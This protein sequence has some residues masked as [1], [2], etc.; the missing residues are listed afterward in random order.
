[1]PANPPF[2]IASIQIDVAV[3]NPAAYGNNYSVDKKAIW[4]QIRLASRNFKLR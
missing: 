4:R 3:E 1:M 2:G